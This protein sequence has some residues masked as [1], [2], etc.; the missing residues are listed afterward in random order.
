MRK[1]PE[2]IT[3]EELHTLV[4]DPKVR[5]NKK[6]ITTYLLAFYQCLR[7]S[8]LIKLTRDCYDHK[9]GF[10]AIKQAKGKKDR[11][12][13]LDKNCVRLIKHLPINKSV[14]TLERWIKSDA[15]RV[16]KRDLHFHSLRHS[17][18]THYLTEKK[19]NIRFLQQFLGHSSINTTQVYTHVKNTDLAKAMWGEIA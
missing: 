1:L 16:L 13:P 6:K 18:A 4:S 17:G 3:E 7:V 2:Y 10:L 5:R 15:L 11:N 14:R 8:E 9:T 12:I 19:W